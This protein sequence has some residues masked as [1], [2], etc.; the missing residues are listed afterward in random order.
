M[1]YKLAKQLRDA[2]FPQKESTGKKICTYR[3]GADHSCSEDFC[4]KDEITI[5]ILEELIDACGDRFSYVKQFDDSSGFVAREKGQSGFH[6]EIGKTPTEA[7]AKL[8]LKL[9]E[10]DEK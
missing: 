8:W 2:G 6:E 5:P 3:G 9:N 4:L 7:V 10:K 1:N